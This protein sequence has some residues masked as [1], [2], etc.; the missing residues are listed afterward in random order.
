MKRNN[1]I[2]LCKN[3]KCL[4]QLPKDYKYKCCEACRNK[5][6]ERNKTIAMGTA[7]VVM[8]VPVAVLA[9]VKKFK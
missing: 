5:K 6:T 2:K 4:K 3:K 9:I 1:E 8:A 7:T